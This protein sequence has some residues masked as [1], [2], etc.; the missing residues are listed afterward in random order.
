L[1]DLANYDQEQNEY[2]AS[3]E[4]TDDV[5]ANFTL[6]ASRY[7]IRG[8]QYYGTLKDGVAVGNSLTST[9]KYGTRVN[10]ET[11]AKEAKSIINVTNGTTVAGAVSSANT[12]LTSGNKGEVRLSVRIKE[13]VAEG[14]LSGFKG[15]N[16]Y[17]RELEGVNIIPKDFSA[18][19]SAGNIFTVDK[20]NVQVTKMEDSTGI[21]VYQF[22]IPDY[23]V[24]AAVSKKTHTE[25]IKIGFSIS[26]TCPTTAYSLAD[27][28]LM[29]PMNQELKVQNTGVLG[30]V[31]QNQYGLGDRGPTEYFFTGLPATAIAIQA[32]IDFNVTTAANID[33]G[34]FIAYNGTPET[35][36]DLNPEG[37]ARYGLKIT[38]NSGQSVKG[39]RAIIPIPKKGE[40]TVP[41]YQLQEDPFGWTVNL[42]KPLDLSA[43]NY[44]YTVLY[45]TKYELDYDAN[46]WQTWEDIPDKTEIRAIYIQT[47][48]VIG[49]MENGTVE[50]P[51]EDFITFSIDMDKTTADQDAGRINIYKALIRR[52]ING[53]VMTIPSEAVA[54]RLKTGVIKGQ[55][56][57]DVNR[58]GIQE[59]NE[60]GLN[61]VTVIAYE[62]GTKK[63]I[64]TTTTRTIDG[65]AGSY[66]FL[67]LD[68]SQAVDVMF[69]NPT[70]DD[71]RRFV[72]NATAVI[73]PDG[74]TAKV[75][76]V[77]ASSQQAD[78]V[79][80]GMM[81][82][83]KAIYDAQG[84]SSAITEEL[85][86]YPDNKAKISQNPTAAKE[87]YDFLG[88]YTQAISGTKV[89]FPFEVSG[90]EDVVLYAHYIEKS[91]TATYDIAAN[92][93]EGKA[94]ASETVKFSERLAK[95]TDPTKTGHA[96][97]G[98]YDK[99]VG[100]KKWNFDE[101]TMPAH[102]LTLYA[103][104]SVNSYFLTF[105]DSGKTKKQTVVYDTL[106]VEPDAP[107][108][109][110]HTFMGWYDK[111]SG[112]TKW[113][114]S[115]NTM[116]PRNLT[117]YARYTINSYTATF[118]VNG[119]TLATDTVEYNGFVKKPTEEPQAAEGYE[120]AGWKTPD[121]SIFW[122]FTTDRMP[123]KDLTLVAQ[124]KPQ[125]QVIKLDFAGG[126]SSGPNQITAPTNSQVD[127]D[128]IMVPVKPGYQFAGWLCEGQPINGTIP[129]P[130]GG[131]TL[132]AQWES[133][134]QVVRFNTNGGT[135]VDPIIAKTGTTITVSGQTTIRPGYEFLGWYDK[136]EQQIETYIVEPGGT[137][138]TAKWKA[139]DQ[140]ITFDVNGGDMATQPATIVQPTDTKIKLNAL[141]TPKR[142][143]YV[144]VGWFDKTG[145][146]YAGTIPMPVGGL[147]LTAQ[148]EKERPKEPMSVDKNNPAATSSN[149]KTSTNKTKKS[150]KTTKLAKTKKTTMKKKIL[151]KSGEV[152]IPSIRFTGFLLLLLTGILINLKRKRY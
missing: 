106:A 94:P 114:F 118:E 31:A 105:N 14:V 34:D 45:A 122:N 103:H 25:D 107:T 73:S 21:T 81:T 23:D 56:Y 125:N 80:I 15:I 82:P 55:V 143:G 18:V 58:N 88:W 126:F 127:I 151:P 148:W 96:F 54:I 100:G 90:K 20:G 8:L 91:Y 10:F 41:A 13:D 64:E 99:S 95:P 130:I 4:W 135:G 132:Q 116:P 133:V 66:V 62:K 146:K 53:A 63:V 150:K 92:G 142:A 19:D 17:A 29:E 28:V 3:V 67:G 101:D 76:N 147:D 120:F 35:I 46:S 134:D 129:M 43:N 109:T 104:F 141:A 37:N 89:V 79:S 16:I 112:G 87:G 152:T 27:V 145:K 11:A 39:Y 108:K 85:L 111:E 51:G 117:L 48:S 7:G 71:S 1:I 70:L 128:A 78:Q 60:L 52:E 75:S 32:N 59:L 42:T 144:F 136:K 24:N 36:I 97:I 65:K 138:F 33:D 86:G 84:G 137:V 50:D 40:T 38:N 22:A 69:K 9:I 140:T 110:G 61:G 68:K 149:K 139:L 123:A 12:R 131:L 30:G 74:A 83:I 115:V 57:N 124:F 121:S 47:N 98:W 2:I 49:P 6:G 77:I 102:D 44:D 5:P 93:G 72:G 26:R 119:T 113:D